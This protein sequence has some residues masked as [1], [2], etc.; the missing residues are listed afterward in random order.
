MRGGGGT[1][2][3]RE[4]RGERHRRRR[5]RA[6]EEEEEEEKR[7]RVSWEREVLIATSQGRC[8]ALIKSGGGEGVTCF[9]SL[10][11]PLASRAPGPADFH[12]CDTL[13]NST[14]RCDSPRTA[15]P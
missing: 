11:G 6:E 10:A 5:R 13:I 12:R 1:R 9:E 4:E 7:G 3:R 14:W 2:L 15:R 8:S